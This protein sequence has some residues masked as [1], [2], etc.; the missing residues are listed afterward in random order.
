MRGE[1][2]LRARSGAVS[3]SGQVSMEYLFIIGFALLLLLP[4]IIVYA[5]ETSRLAEQTTA[6]SAHRAAQLIAEAADTVYYLGAPTTRRITIDLPENIRSA[7][8]NGT[9]IIFQVSSSSGDYDE[10]AWSA[11]NLTGTLPTTKGPHSLT[12]AALEDGR[13]SIAAS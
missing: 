4:L 8:V 5:T 12:I 6:A 1:S 11:A 9:A 10:V 7:R 3:R 2:S 13:V